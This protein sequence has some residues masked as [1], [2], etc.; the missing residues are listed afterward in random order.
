MSAMRSQL[1]PLPAPVRWWYVGDGKHFRGLNLS[2]LCSGSTRRERK[3]D[4][5]MRGS[6]D[7]AGLNCISHR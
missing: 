4:L 7:D 3:A 1:L 5:V 6:E 2:C